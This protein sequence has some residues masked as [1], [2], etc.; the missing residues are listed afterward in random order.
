MFGYA[1]PR[2]KCKDGFSMSVQDGEHHYAIPGE[3]SEV[4]F[5]S[6]IEELLMPYVEDDERPLD[7]VYAHVP[8]DI[9]DKIIEKH[10]G[11]DNG[12]D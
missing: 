4:G 1:R 3:T 8:N 11:Y 7:T 2:I 9:V 10:G 6:E 5:P 12:K